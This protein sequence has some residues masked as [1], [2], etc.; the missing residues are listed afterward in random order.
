MIFHH[1]GFQIELGET[2]TQF[3][4]PYIESDDFLLLGVPSSRNRQNS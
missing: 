1:G 3:T 4:Y 2:F